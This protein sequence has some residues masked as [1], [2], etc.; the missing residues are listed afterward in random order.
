MSHGKFYSVVCN[1]LEGKKEWMCMCD[2]F[3][4]LYPGNEYNTV[5]QLRFKKIKLKKKKERK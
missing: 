2:G 5:S 4:V 3:T 1:H